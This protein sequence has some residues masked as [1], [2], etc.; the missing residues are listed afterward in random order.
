MVPPLWFAIMN[1]RVMAVSD[2]T[3]PKA[4]PARAARR[5]A[6]EAVFDRWGGY[7]MAALIVGLGIA[8]SRLGFAN[9]V[10]YAIV[11]GAVFVLLRE[12]FVLAPIAARAK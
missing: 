3:P 11:V 6:V 2:E 7:L 12:T 1:P 4:A 10:L 5:Q 8:S 9:A